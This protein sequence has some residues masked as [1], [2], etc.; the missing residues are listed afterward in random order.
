MLRGGGGAGAAPDKTTEAVLRGGGGAG[1]APDKTTKAVL[2]GG[3]GAGAAPDKTT[4][5]VLRA[6]GRCEVERV[7]QARVRSSAWQMRVLI[8]E[9][10][11][12]MEKVANRD[13]RG[14]RWGK[15]NKPIAELMCQLN[16]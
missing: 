14:S 13:I 2:R 1:A 12:A 15:G 7:L 16:R 10:G 9:V 6:R 11:T 4:K 5:A 3:G 8:Q